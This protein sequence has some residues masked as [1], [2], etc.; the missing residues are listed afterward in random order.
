MAEQPQGSAI[1]PEGSYTTGATSTATKLP[2]SLRETPQSVSV[3]TR[4]LVDDQ[5]LSTLNEVL[6]NYQVD[7]H[8]SV[9]LNVNNLFD[10]KYYDGMGTFNSGS[11]GEPRNAMVN[12]KWKF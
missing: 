6:A 1:S 12:A 9:G 3:V 5:H 11:Y 2:L 7:E 8:L 10:K 4:Q